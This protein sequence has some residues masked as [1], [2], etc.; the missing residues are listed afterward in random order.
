M[1]FRMFNAATPILIVGPSGIGK[2]KACSLVET[3]FPQCSFAD[4]DLIAGR[5]AFNMGIIPE[6]DVHRL[7]QHVSDAQLL[8]G[9]GLQA[10]GAFVIDN[11]G[12][13]AVIDMGAG[14][15]VGRSAEHLHKIHPLIT[16]GASPAAAY[17]RFVRFRSPRDEKEFF[18]TEFNE[19]R[20]KVYGSAQ[21]RID[22]TDLTLEQSADEL[23]AAIERIIGGD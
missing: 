2:T 17:S 7:V 9:V 19:H 20:S 16:I 10:I 4:L 6:A 3:R 13:R 1:M 14:F 5:Y 21:H 23:A 15:Q 12:R 18:E 11:T 8:L 22:T